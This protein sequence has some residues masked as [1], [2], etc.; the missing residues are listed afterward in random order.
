VPGKS[1]AQAWDKRGCRGCHGVTI[2]LADAG[3]DET[4]TVDDDHPDKPDRPV[5]GG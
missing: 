2:K 4:P 5:E 3:I 1:A